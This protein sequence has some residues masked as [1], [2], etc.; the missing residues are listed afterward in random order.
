MRET[1]IEK[2]KISA[3]ITASVLAGVVGIF[4]LIIR[5]NFYRPWWS[6]Y[7]A[8]NLELL[9][10]MSG[11]ICGYLAIKNNYGRKAYFT[12]G[13]VLLFLFLQFFIFFSIVAFLASLVCLIYFLISPAINSMNRWVYGIRTGSFRCDIFIYTGVAIGLFLCSIWLYETWVPVS[14]T[15]GMGCSLK[16]E[17]LSQAI[18][19]YQRDNSGKYPTANIWCDLLLKTGQIEKDDFIC[20]EVKFRWKRQVFPLPIPK[21]KR[22]YY[23]MNPNCEPNSPANTVLLFETDGGWN[24]YGGPEL[25]STKNHHWAL[26]HI[27]YNDGHVEFA[28]KEK[29]QYLKWK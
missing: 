1:I 12:L 7:F 13:Y 23:A 22:C 19:I 24:V 14:T 18:L 11:L 8:R 27:L 9:F 16:L 15:V 26:C 28:R 4:I 29:L 25:L 10:G 5:A 17:K 2:P 20:P 6:E 3:L 21:N